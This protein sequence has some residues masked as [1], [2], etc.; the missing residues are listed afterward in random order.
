[1]QSDYVVDLHGQLL[2]DFLGRYE[3]LADDFAEACRRIGI[4]QPAL[5][6]RRQANDRGRDYRRYYSDDLAALVAQH[7]EPDI[8]RFGYRFDP[9]HGG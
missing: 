1:M 9:P 7:F 8:R 3:T 6:H 4:A 5:P 2:V